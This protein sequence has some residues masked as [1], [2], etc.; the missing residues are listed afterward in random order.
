[1][2]DLGT[3]MAT[4]AR[5]GSP[6]SVVLLSG[7]M[8]STTALAWARRPVLALSVDYGQRHVRELRAA[9]AV[10][11]HYGVRHEILDLTGWGRLLKGSSLTD[12]TV[13]VPEGHYAAP[14]MAATVVPNRNATMLMA[15]VG[16][17]ESIGAEQVVAAVHSGDHAV[18]ADCRPEFIEAA[19]RTAQVATDGKV[20]VY[21]PFVHISKTDIAR[22][23]A[24]LEAP[25]HLSWSCYQGGE[26]HCGRCGT[27]YERREAFRD[28]RLVDPTEYESEP[29]LDLIP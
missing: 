9:A 24:A 16:V 13:A 5:G 17:A 22:V 21:A 26:R 15:A 1:M 10:A 4:R 14:T 23:G 8:D 25:L 7:G 29:P 11:H 3:F 6:A 20:R 18:Y 27:C 19:T 28:A 12:P 2:T